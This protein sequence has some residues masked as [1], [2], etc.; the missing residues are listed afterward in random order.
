[1]KLSLPAILLS[2]LLVQFNFTKAQIDTSF[3][4]AAP[5]V[6]PD[7]TWRDDVK[8]HISTFSAIT[9]TVRV[10]QPSAIAP[11]KYDTTIVIP[12]FTTFD[13]VFWRDKLA[14]ATNF[15]FDSLETRPA[16]SVVPYG[17]YLSS[18]SPITVVYDVITR[19]PGFLNPETFSMKGRNAIGKEFLCPF[20]TK[21]RNNTMT[22]DLNGDGSVTQPKQQI[23][24][25]ATQSNTVVWITPKCDAIGHLS[26]ITYSV[27]LPNPGSAYTIENANQT[28]T[29]S[30]QNLSGTLITSDK[31]IAVTVADDSVKGN[32]GCYDL[33]GDQIVPVTVIGK[34]Y[35][36]VKGAMN[37]IEPEGAF[38]LAKD[39]N[40]QLIISDG[41]VT[42]VT[43]NAG[44]TYHYPTTQPVTYINSDKYV[45]V[46]H[47]TGI[48][49]ELGEALLPPI[50]CSGSNLISFSRTTQQKFALN[51][52]CR[53]GS[54]SSFTLA[55][56]TSLVPAT[57]FTLVP[58][59]STVNGGPYFGAQVSLTS[60]VLPIG[61]YT[62][63]NNVDAFA[64]GVFDGDFSS[65]TMYHYLSSFMNPTDVKA[66]TLA[67]LCINSTNSVALTGTV[68]GAASTGIWTS[69][70][71]T[72][73]FSPLYTST[74]NIIS[75]TYTLSNLD[76]TKTFLKFYLI[77]AGTCRPI[78]DS[79]TLII[80]HKPVISVPGNITLCRNNLTPIN[81]S[82]TVMNALS[83]QWSGGNG[84]TF[85]G[86][87]TTVS[88]SLSAADV[89][90]T[91]IV[92]TL[93]SHGPLTSCANSAKT[94]TLN[95]ID[96]AIVNAGAD[97]I[98]CGKTTPGVGLYGNVSGLTS[99]GIWSG[100]GTGTFLPS[101]G[102]STLS[103]LFSASDYLLTSFVFTLTSTNNGFCVSVNDLVQVLRDTSSVNIHASS[104]TIC[105][106][107]SATL[108]AVG[109]PTVLWNTAGSFSSFVVFPTTTTSYSVTGTTTLNCNYTDTI[110]ITVSPL[111]EVMASASSTGICVGESLI[112]DG[113]G[114]TNYTWTTIPAFTSSVI[115]SPTLATVYY[116]L[117]KDLAGCKNVDSVSVSILECTGINEREEDLLL[118]YPNPSTGEFIIQSSQKMTLR[119]IDR[120]GQLVKTVELN[121][122]NQP[123][124]SV[125]D[126]ATGV[127]FVDGVMGNK[128]IRRKI[129]IEK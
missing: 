126:L 76:T 75:T 120:L 103:Y 78:S 96:P 109:T 67:P 6:T 57:A 123:K 80:N 51:I 31:P 9:T 87:G 89:S 21:W 116:L 55:G 101:A 10:R 14:S 62:I 7:H 63:G 15:G 59:T 45:Y 48:G 68:S 77:S 35:I 60:S 32:G 110:T 4:F 47:A 18:S 83:A 122:A 118:I 100:P 12:A 92:F 8:L 102:S 88:Y 11:N 5:W 86:T 61:S 107:Q 36:V 73:T 106:N 115:V 64:L 128:S 44:D 20:Q 50:N 33:M 22:F 113:S 119:F 41:T 81:L 2:I 91:A 121:E 104:T 19:A 99:T 30:A 72:G 27:L 54:Q 124:L 71:G 34:E 49:C 127:Y 65:G 108:T 111:P 112:L 117:G 39:N 94:L 40:T 38:V 56:S 69:A 26:G 1:M 53:N 90:A 13:Y 28:T 74:T 129:V 79:I 23:N 25:V 58:G 125:S 29:I 84:G 85:T 66:T 97:V 82:G 37:A 105:V 114:A 43:I 98:L 52:L 93:A 42:T 17:L 95:F 46:L 70:N 24:I 16:N 3:W